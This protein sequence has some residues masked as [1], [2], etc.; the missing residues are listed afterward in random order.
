MGSFFQLSWWCYYRQISQLLLWVWISLLGFLSPKSVQ[1][2]KA[3]CFPFLF[4]CG[5]SIPFSN[6][7]VSDCSGTKAKVCE[8]YKENPGNSLCYCSS[9]SEVPIQSVFFY[10]LESLELFPRSLIVFREEN[11]GEKSPCHCTRTRLSWLI[12]IYYNL[13]IIVFLLSW[14]QPRR[15]LF[16]RQNI[17]SVPKGNYSWNANWNQW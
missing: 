16:F 1:R 17:L 14:L 3:F 13:N 6:L 10:L 5:G 7:G 4:V 9:S 12:F 8:W 15:V 2:E 11:K